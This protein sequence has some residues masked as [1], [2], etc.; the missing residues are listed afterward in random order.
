M[1]NPAIDLGGDTGYKTYKVAKKGRKIEVF[2]KVLE[3]DTGI[4]MDKGKTIGIIT[5]KN[6]ESILM[7]AHSGY[8]TGPMRQ[9]KCLDTQKWNLLA[10]R[11][12]G[13]T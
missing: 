2:V 10:L 13:S 11:K 7:C 4:S 5:A 12:M 6:D 1:S 8:S 9:E 3:V